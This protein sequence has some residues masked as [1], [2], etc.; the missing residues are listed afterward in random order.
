MIRLDWSVSVAGEAGSCTALSA[1]LACRG[2]AEVKQIVD[3]ELLPCWAAKPE[4]CAAAINS[5]VSSQ[6]ACRMESAGQRAECQLGD[7]LVGACRQG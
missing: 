4:S 5:C 1:Q 3:N 2:I 6:S 7:A